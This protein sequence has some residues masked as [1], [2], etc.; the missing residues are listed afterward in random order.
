MKCTAR[1]YKMNYDFS[2]EFAEAHHD[3]NESE[4]NRFYDWEDELALTNEV[5]D[6][7]VI[8][9]GVYQLQ[10]EKGGEAFTEDIKNVV[11]FN[12]IGEDDSVTQMA[13]S[14]S[15]VMKFDVEKTEN[16]IN[17]SVYLEEM[18]PLTNPIP[19]IYIA[20]QD[21]PKFLVD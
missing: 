5:K 15:L 1:F 13:C 18:E 3:G 10:G 8:E 9:E 4:N 11:L 7:E 14:K 17:L 20:I 21:F 12:I 16:E 2:P 19:G 6:I